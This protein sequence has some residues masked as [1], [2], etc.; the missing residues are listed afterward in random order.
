MSSLTQVG[1]YDCICCVADCVA[2]FAGFS[3]DL[4]NPTASEGNVTWAAGLRIT[5]SRDVRAT[6]GGDDVPLSCFA[7]CRRRRE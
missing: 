2:R 6:V 5:L 3:H 7:N 4:V 1:K